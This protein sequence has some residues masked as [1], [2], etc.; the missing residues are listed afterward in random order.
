[1]LH[2]GRK[3]GRKPD[4]LKKTPTDAREKEPQVHSKELFVASDDELLRAAAARR[5]CYSLPMRKLR[6]VSGVYLPSL[7]IKQAFWYFA[8]A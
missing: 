7:S 3:K 4:L 5:Q 2:Q 1:M 6:N 8:S